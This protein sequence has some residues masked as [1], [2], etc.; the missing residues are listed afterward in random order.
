MPTV[1][2][3]GHD[4]RKQPFVQPFNITLDSDPEAF[5]RRLYFDLQLMFEKYKLA[6]GSQ[7]GKHS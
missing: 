6:Q 5:T 1:R 4:R 2:F 3:Q 7:H